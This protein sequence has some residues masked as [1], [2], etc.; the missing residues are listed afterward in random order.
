M[1]N[2]VVVV[3]IDVY[4][5]YSRSQATHWRQLQVSVADVELK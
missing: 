4:S 5:E 3:V 2:V 1:V